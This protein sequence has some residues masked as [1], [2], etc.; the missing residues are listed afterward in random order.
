[1]AHLG[2]FRTKLGQTLFTDVRPTSVFV[3]TKQDVNDLAYGSCK[4]IGLR[5]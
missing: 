2:V 5:R 4:Q 3:F 1:M